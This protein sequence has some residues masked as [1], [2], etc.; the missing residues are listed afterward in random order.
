MRFPPFFLDEIRA[1]LPVSDVVGQS[2]RLRKQGREWAGLSPFNKE[3]TPSFFVNDQKGFYHC[4]S[5]GK[6]GDVFDFLM[7]TQGLPFP[8]AVETLANMAGLSLPKP[9]PAFEE[10]TRQRAGLHEIMEMAARFFTAQLGASA[11][12][13]ARGYIGRRG[14]TRETCEAFGL[15]YAPS[16]RTALKRHLLA[17]GV[18]L[19]DALET[20]M[21]IGGEDIPDPYDRFRDRVM[22]PIHDM[23]GR[24]I[25]F[26]GRA[27]A[28]DAKAKYLNSPE[29]PLFHKGQVLY[30]HHRA[31][32]AAH[33][34]GT[35]VAVEGYMDVIALAQ[36]GFNHAVAPLGTALTPDQIELLWRMADE[37]ILCFDGDKAGQR[38]AGRAIDTALPALKPGKS[39][40]FAF[41][42]EGQDPDDLINNSGRAAMETVLERAS[43]F[44]EVLW[45]RET[46]GD[47]QA[48]P[49]R[50]A[51]AE[52]RLHKL[53]NTIRDETVRK[54]YHTALNDKLRA[55][56]SA[57]YASHNRQN[58]RAPFQRRTGFGQKA[59][60]PPLT[61]SPHLGRQGMMAPARLP[62]REATLLMAVVRHPFL[63]ERFG[64]EIASVEF[65]APD[66]AA[67]QRTVLSLSAEEAAAT[68]GRMEAEVIRVSGAAL[69]S[70]VEAAV[71]PGTWWIRADSD[72]NDVETA[73]GHTLAL[74][75]KTHALH[76]ELVAAETALGLD[77]T[78]SN[79][80]RLAEIQ[81]ELRA[82][83]GTEAII[84][85]FGVA[86][87]RRGSAM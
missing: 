47:A 1:R 78:E 12:H 7:E 59:F 15:G 32:T 83:E 41:L 30:N 68:A 6:H 31:R 5:S 21:L 43:P 49:E 25:A 81:A 18:A 33:Q 13:E 64:E 54:H 23:R 37:P 56:G 16:D 9:D 71:A 50:R 67:L 45:A 63:L 75:I 29:T 52:S 69:I 42:P 73:F 4:F 62:A 87:N 46:G 17:K 14:L 38:A 10:T 22:F 44:V 11:G 86:S 79:F 61:A 72:Q 24:I 35:V 70:R 48:T 51:A 39:L 84:D 55:L 20:G 76:K 58:T 74:H 36:A 57:R 27:L 53:V 80:A 3:K 66:L 65:S 40:R 2:V 26:G 85:G 34:A 19:A 8:D 77:L 60:E 82:V 28:K